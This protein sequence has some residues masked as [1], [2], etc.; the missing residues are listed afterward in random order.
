MKFIRKVFNYFDYKLGR[1]FFK[2]DNNFLINLIGHKELKKKIINFEINEES[3]NLKNRGFT[4]IKP[5]QISKVEEIKKIFNSYCLQNPN[6]KRINLEI[7]DDII[8]KI[9]QL[10][11]SNKNFLSTI[12]G[13]FKSN[14]VVGEIN[15]YRNKNFIKDDAIEV[16][17]ENFHCDHYKK[18]MVKIFINLS[19]IEKVNGPLEIFDKKKTKKIIELGYYDRNNYGNAKDYLSKDDNKYLNLGEIGDSLICSTTE[20]LHRASIPNK[21]CSRDVISVSLF[22]DNSLNFN[23]IKYMDEIN[24]GIAKKLGKLNFI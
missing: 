10:L 16:M 14:Y 21:N 9:D 11:Q 3:N 1:F 6:E 24:K 12:N 4:K 8:R 19:K 18:T 15:I 20:C 17:N 23:P 7:D 2:N 5:F 22:K 13:Y